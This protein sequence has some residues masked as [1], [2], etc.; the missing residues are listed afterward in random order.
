MFF[1]GAEPAEQVGDQERN[2]PGV[3][4]IVNDCVP[5]RDDTRFT[6]IGRVGL[7]IISGSAELENT[8]RA[9]HTARTVKPA[10]SAASLNYNIGIEIFKKNTNEYLVYNINYFIFA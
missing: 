8:F 10:N 7:P 3:G 1:G 2:T 6:S 5:Q 9:E 4:G